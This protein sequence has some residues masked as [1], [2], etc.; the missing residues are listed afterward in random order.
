MRRLFCQITGLPGYRDLVGKCQAGLPH[1]ALL[2]PAARHYL[3][4]LY[5]VSSGPTKIGTLP[6]T[7]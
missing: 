3:P 1:P 7:G 4:F 6:F 5:S 2:N